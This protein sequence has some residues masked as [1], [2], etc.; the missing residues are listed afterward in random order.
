MLWTDQERIELGSFC[1]IAQDVTIFGG[2]EHNLE[3]V[4][5]YPLRIALGHPLAWQDGHPKTK[6]PTKIGSDVWI[7][8][9]STILSGTTVGHGAVIG[10][11]T[12][13]TGDVPAYAIV[14]G[15]PARLVRYRFE[16]R[17]IARLLEIAW[18]NWPL[19]KIDENV[20]LLCGG[21]VD[22]FLRIEGRQIDRSTSEYRRE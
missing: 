15:N 11:G 9:G 21:S 20:S 5:T 6:G 22:E 4:T 3:W 13:V 2:G 14:A 1:S 10:A 18:W 17:T 19:A 7:G 8:H 16:P 12:V